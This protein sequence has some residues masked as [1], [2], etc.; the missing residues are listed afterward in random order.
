MSRRNLCRKCKVAPAQGDKALA[1]DGSLCEDCDARVYMSFRRLVLAMACSEEDE[2]SVEDL[3]RS[4][5]PLPRKAPSLRTMELCMQEWA[6]AS[7][8]GP[9]ESDPPLAFEWP[10]PVGTDSLGWWREAN[11]IG[12][13]N[14]PVAIEGMPDDALVGLV[15]E[16]DT[17]VGRVRLYGMVQPWGSLKSWSQ[18]YDQPYV[19]LPPYK[20]PMPPAGKDAARQKAQELS[21]WYRK[22]ILG[23]RISGRPPGSMSD[24]PTEAEVRAY[25]QACRELLPGDRGPTAIAIRMGAILPMNVT[26]QWVHRWMERGAFPRDEHGPRRHRRGTD[27]A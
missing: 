19:S 12:E 24:G 11:D 7:W 3:L 25:H 21:R 14:I 8:P 16:R 5:E 26:A 27:S 18:F 20:Y 23:L 6:M 13:A 1:L 15:I 10:L 9:I 2:P 17:E 22:H 4:N